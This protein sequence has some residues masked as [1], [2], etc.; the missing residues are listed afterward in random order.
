MLDRTAGYGKHIITGF[1][2]KR[3]AF[4]EPVSHAFAACIIGRRS[5]SPIA[6]LSIE[7][8]QQPSRRWERLLWI[9]RIVE[10]YRCSGFR[11]ELRNS[12]RAGAADRVRV[13][14]A[15]L[16][17][18]VREKNNRQTIGLRRGDQRITQRV[19]LD[20]GRDFVFLIPGS[21]EVGG[22]ARICRIAV[23]LRYGSSCALVIPIGRRIRVASA[24][25]SV[26]RVFLDGEI[27]GKDWRDRQGEGTL[28]RG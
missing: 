27:A 6:E 4:G 28:V 1:F 18:Q 25:T 3:G 23:T 14:P 17:D 11:H 19:G 24:G 13:K 15:F 5:K 26:M 20:C 2:R 12:Q 7:P 10:A 8:G 9:E 22:I 21:G 16:P